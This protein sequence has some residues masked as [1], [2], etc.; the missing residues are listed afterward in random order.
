MTRLLVFPQAALFRTGGGLR[1]VNANF[2][3]IDAL[4]DAFS[5]VTV[6]ARVVDEPGGDSPL[7][8][9]DVVELP[10]YASRTDFALR[11]PD[12]RK[13]ILRALE[14]ADLALVVLPGYLGAVAS[15]T[16]RRA[17]VPLV[18]F[19]V[20]RW[21]RVVL[22]RR[23]GGPGRLRARLIAPLLDATVARLT[24]DSLTFHNSAVPSGAPGCHYARV[25]STYSAS[26]L[27]SGEPVRLQDEGP[28]L[29]F[30]G[31][32]AAEKGL[33]HLFEAV[34]RLRRVG[35]PVTLEVVGDGEQRIALEREVERLG[36]G[37]SVRFTGWLTRGDALWKR[38]DRA[39]VFVLPSLEDM[40]PRVLLEAM[41]R[42]VVVVATDVGHVSEVVRDGDTGLL[43]EPGSTR[44]I[45]EAVQRLWD[46]P[47]LRERLV[48]SG[49]T[50]AAK[51][52]LEAETAKTVSI[53]RRH[54]ALE[55]TG[56]P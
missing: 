33:P 26:D 40:A 10:P 48:A 32:L 13:R 4:R 34:A 25:S 22:S 6:C 44:A 45:A 30:A 7:P 52:T 24:R 2:A 3:Q 36:L 20:G 11:I 17:R 15:W 9:I 12:Y 28:R 27:R 23:P 50:L 1:T 51:H 18:H 14:E 42:K 31:R 53:I 19:V 21:G 43:I 39:E 55:Y 38:F 37:G 46:E 29:V 54:F 49:T 5:R 56:R 8:D 35:V 41:A 47:E 16:C